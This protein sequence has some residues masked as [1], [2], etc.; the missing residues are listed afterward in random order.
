MHQIRE[1]ATPILLNFSHPHLK[2]DKKV[3]GAL[4][5]KKKTPTMAKI[6]KFLLWR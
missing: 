4:G 5:T 3:S 2:L 1:G 6:K